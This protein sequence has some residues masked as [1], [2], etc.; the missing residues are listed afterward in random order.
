MKFNFSYNFRI[1]YHDDF[2]MQEIIQ[3]AGPIVE[4]IQASD[5]D[6]EL[7]FKSLY[8]FK[9]AI[10]E[11][12]GINMDIIY[13][14]LENLGSISNGDNLF[15]SV[16]CCRPN[17]SLKQNP[18]DIEFNEAFLSYR[19]N[20]RDKALI[21]E[22][23]H[24]YTIDFT[25]EGEK[26]ICNNG[27]FQT[28][29]DEIIT[30]KTAMKIEEVLGYEI[31]VQISNPTSNKKGR[32]IDTQLESKGTGYDGIINF[33]NAL[34]SIYGEEAVFREKYLQDGSVFN[35]QIDGISIQD[36]D[37]KITNMAT[38]ITCL[39]NRIEAQNL[40]TDA[41]IKKWEN[42]E[43]NMQE[44]I[45]NVKSISGTGV[46]AKTADVIQQNEFD[47]IS[48]RLQNF[49][50]AQFYNKIAGPNVDIYKEMNPL[51]RSENCKN[52]L[53]VMEGLKNL[54]ISFSTEDLENM[55][56]RRILSLPNSQI[57]LEVGEKT[58]QMNYNYD[59]RFGMATKTE[60]KEL[61]LTS[62][63]SS[64]LKLTD[65]KEGK[66]VS[67]INL[68]EGNIY[69][70]GLDTIRDIIKKDSSNVSAESY[71][72]AACTA[73][74]ITT[75]NK[76]DLSYILENVAL[77]KI[78]DSYGN[79]LLHAIAH[80][81]SPSTQVVLNQMIEYQ[82]KVVMKLV[83]KR[84]E[85]GM[86]PLEES[87]LNE[88]A[89]IV[90]LLVENGNI[91]KVMELFNA[92]NGSFVIGENQ[93]AAGDILFKLG[94]EDLMLKMM[95][96]GIGA[97][98]INSSGENVIF[99]YARGQISRDRLVDFIN[100]GADVNS[101]SEFGWTT[102]VGITIQNGDIERM[103]KLLKFNA[104]PNC[105]QEL[106]NSKYMDSKDPEATVEDKEKGIQMFKMLIEAGA[107]PNYRGKYEIYTLLQ[108]FGGIINDEPDYKMIKLLVDSGA[109]PLDCGSGNSP[110]LRDFAAV[111][112]D[113]EIFKIM[114]A[115][116]IN[117]ESLDLD[118]SNLTAIEK[119]IVSRIE[120]EHHEK[121]ENNK[122]ETLSHNKT[123]NEVTYTENERKV[124][125]V[126]IK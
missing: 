104:N 83:T 86:T 46:I 118:N 56:Y 33:G 120:P 90:C 109:N 58:Y 105:L 92:E 112:G 95:K 76:K 113:V 70:G 126:A 53:V 28:G 84:N 63:I 37:T 47:T 108:R 18:A 121:M 91:K 85:K 99:A 103:S 97:N 54:N 43:I 87:I 14:R 78:T 106:F 32:V 10:S 35:T 79:N 52:F 57:I 13:S 80:N 8:G 34:F 66:G 64:S 119:A 20:L 19:N 1:Q 101:H 125:K 3:K 122:A 67:F 25:I 6:K 15:L 5:D 74:E 93:I 55:K 65:I 81:S 75:K 102:P 124:I 107:D 12:Y 114:A 77:Q 38:N 2:E 116:G 88:N 48:S 51:T 26:R 60:L 42:S 44:Y 110:S 62:K 82:P 24:L 94:N 21:H 49:E 16:A 100:A 117:K 68:I 115:A 50:I 30:E 111:R 71:L 9:K 4:K 69:T 98:C 29:F 39:E 7:I 45:K 89:N 73:D 36:I 23:C 41:L 72:L 22:L 27:K 61:S 31:E 17:E 59:E 40:L 123:N 11:P 96:E